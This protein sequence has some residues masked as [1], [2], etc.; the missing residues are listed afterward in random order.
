[1]WDPKEMYRELPEILSK[2]L[3]QSTIITHDSN[4]EVDF[5]EER[6]GPDVKMNIVFVS[7]HNSGE[8]TIKYAT[9][10]TSIDVF[11]KQ[12]LMNC[13]LVILP[14]GGILG[15]KEYGQEFGTVNDEEYNNLVKNQIDNLKTKYNEIPKI[16]IHRL[17]V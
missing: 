13:E 5:Y 3:L 14:K 4:Y 11:R 6:I 8:N 2:Y 10:D 9:N 16:Q 7:H 15:K 12:Q 17:V 1:M